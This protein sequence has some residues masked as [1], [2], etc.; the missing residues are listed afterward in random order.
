MTSGNIECSV[1]HAPP[2]ETTMS[3]SRID[4][5]TENAHELSMRT[6]LEEEFK[7]VFGGTIPVTT[8]WAGL[9]FI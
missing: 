5:S 8:P 1:L 6:V 2:K 9:T 7:A 3:D 4:E